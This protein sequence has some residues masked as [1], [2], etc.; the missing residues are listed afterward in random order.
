MQVTCA[1]CGHE[2]PAHLDRCHHCARP[3]LFPNVRAAEEP[4]EQAELQARYQVAIDDADSRAALNEIRAFEAAVAVSEAVATRDVSDVL[5][6][7]T[8]D[9]AIYQTYYELL[10]GGARVAEG[11]EW[12]TRRALADDVIF[13]NYKNHVRFAAL[14]LDGLGLPH[15]GNCHLVYREEMIEYRATAFWENAG[16]WAQRDEVRADPLHPPKGYRSTWQQ[17]ATLAVAKLAHIISPGMT[18]DTFPGILMQPGA[19]GD[20]DQFVEVH[21]WGSVTRRAFKRVS[22][23]TQDPHGTLERLLEERLTAAGVEVRFMP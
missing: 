16:V 5:A 14:S 9:T 20:D 23:R 18:P 2:F 22:V 8:R 19:T 17:R 1:F 10:E 13:P 6:L 15:Y 7:A 11:S 4:G 12:D 3:G 21:I